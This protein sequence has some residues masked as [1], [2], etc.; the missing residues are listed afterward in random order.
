MIS[1]RISP[2]ASLTALQR[3]TPTLLRHSLS[4]T[5][6]NPPTTKLTPQESHQI[7]TAQRLNRPVAPHLSIYEPSQTWF[8]ASAWTRITGC[9][10]SGAAYVY[11]TGYLVAPL[12]GLHLGSAEL[13]A[14]F[15]AWPFFAKGVVK[16]ALAFPFTFHF[17]V[18]VKHLVY[19]LGVGFA[20]GTIR[21][22]EMALWV[23]SL[24]GG[25]F[26]AFGV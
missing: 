2:R 23:A 1:Q 9:S 16:F 18:G 13:A 12:L 11:L 17:F 24:A 15:A 20:K 8:G 10:L 4:T 22:G 25:L 3:A 26:L 14:G 19:D 6:T 7:L 5:Q 21:R